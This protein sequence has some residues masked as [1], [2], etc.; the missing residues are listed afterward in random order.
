MSGIKFVVLGDKIMWYTVGEDF[1][2]QVSEISR[3]RSVGA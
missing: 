1:A 2:V 3:A